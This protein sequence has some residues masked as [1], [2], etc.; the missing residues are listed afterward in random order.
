MEREKLVRRLQE[1]PRA[2]EAEEAHRPPKEFENQ[3][4]GALKTS[5]LETLKRDFNTMKEMTTK[6][7]KKIE[8]KKKEKKVKVVGKGDGNLVEAIQKP[9]HLRSQKPMTRVEVVD[10]A[11]EKDVGK[12]MKTIKPKPEVKIVETKTE[13]PKVELKKE[14][15]QS[16]GFC[17]KME[18]EI[19]SDLSKVHLHLHLH[20]HQTCTKPA[21]APN[22]HQTCRW[23]WW[24]RCRVWPP[25]PAGSCRTG[26][27]CA[28]WSTGPSTSG[29]SRSRTTR[30]SSS[31]A[32]TD[33]FDG[34]VIWWFGGLVVE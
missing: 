13:Q 7:T 18:K 12:V 33:R 25:P 23:S 30:P 15:S 26:G 29:S 5:D 31:P 9:T 20:L 22:L 21:P 34:L 32:S 4:R 17:K 10:V 16:K 28:P 24:R 6:A 14:G 19:S 8:D 3:L 1:K 11:S 27:A 2:E